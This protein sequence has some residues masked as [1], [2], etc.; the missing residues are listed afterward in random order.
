MNVILNSFNGNVGSVV[1]D[2]IGKDSVGI[3]SVRLEYVNSTGNNLPANVYM[4][5][6]IS[7][8]AML[9]PRTVLDLYG[10]S[11]VCTVNGVYGAN[12][13]ETIGGSEPFTVSND[14]DEIVF[15]TKDV[16][17]DVEKSEHSDFIATEV[18]V[19]VDFPT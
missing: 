11:L 10:V 4:R 13:P 2:T 1:P 15:I 9:L 3:R 7:A 19:K 14:T 8:G 17:I 6:H 18:E 12:T 5:A 16:V